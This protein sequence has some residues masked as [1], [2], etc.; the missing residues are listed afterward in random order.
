[1]SPVDRQ[2]IEQLERDLRA[3][4]TAY[5]DVDVS[6][7]AWQR[8]EDL[9]AGGGI[10]RPPQHAHGGGRRCRGAARGRSRL[11][12]ARRARRGG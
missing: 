2:Q 9:V 3:A 6:P 12:G 7:D 4:R 10:R 5:D 8:N 11:A 1:M